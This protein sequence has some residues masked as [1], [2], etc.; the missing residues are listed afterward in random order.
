MQVSTAIVHASKSDDGPKIFPKRDD[1]A[2]KP[3]S[4]SPV[5]RDFSISR[6]VS[7]NFRAKT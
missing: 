7:P 5:G 1:I 3:A 4:E 2:F 6:H